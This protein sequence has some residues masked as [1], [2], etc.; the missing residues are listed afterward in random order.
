[1]KCNHSTKSNDLKSKRKKTVKEMKM[2]ADLIAILCTLFDMSLPFLKDVD[3]DDDVEGKEHVQEL[4]EV[5]C[6][7]F[8]QIPRR[9][10]SCLLDCKSGNLDSKAYSLK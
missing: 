4:R 3:D 10:L 2:R 1:M 6:L 7:R 8:Q 9:N 5:S